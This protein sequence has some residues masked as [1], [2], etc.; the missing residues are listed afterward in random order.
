[1]KSTNP[2]WFKAFA[3]LAMVAY[4]MADV[5]CLCNKNSVA[6]ESKC[7][8]HYV[9]HKYSRRLKAWNNVEKTYRGYRPSTVCNVEITCSLQMVSAQ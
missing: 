3:V 9:I 2:L 6:T 7:A 1:M 4:A 8:D 5:V